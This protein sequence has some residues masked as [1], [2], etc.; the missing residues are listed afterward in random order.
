[1]FRH[2]DAIKRRVRPGMGRCQ[3]G[4]CSPL[5]AEIISKECQIPIEEI[6]KKGSTSQMF[7][8]KTK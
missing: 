1:M 8:G 2:I 7:L 5:V 4:F 6:T 3:G